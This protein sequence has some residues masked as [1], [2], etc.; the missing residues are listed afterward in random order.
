MTREEIIEFGTDYI[1]NECPHYNPNT[2]H[3]NM[4]LN[5]FIAGAESSRQSEIDEFVLAVIDIKS[6]LD[7]GRSQALKAYVDNL[8]KKYK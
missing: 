6:M 3:F 4:L 7:E 5:V 1:H 8:Y 2:S